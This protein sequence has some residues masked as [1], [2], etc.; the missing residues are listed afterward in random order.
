MMLRVSRVVAVLMGVVALQACATQEIEIREARV[1]LMEPYAPAAATLVGQVSLPT[2]VTAALTATVNWG[3]GSAE[4]DLTLDSSG[5]FNS[6]HSFANAGTYAVTVN[7]KAGLNAE[8][9]TTVTATVARPLANVSFECVTCDNSGACTVVADCTFD[10]PTVTF[11]ARSEGGINA[12]RYRW[13]F[14]DNS[15]PL[16][17]EVVSHDFANA[18]TYSVTVVA[19][20]SI[21]SLDSFSKNVVINSIPV[22]E[23]E[24]DQMLPLNNMQRRPAFQGNDSQAPATAILSIR[25]YGEPPITFIV[26]WGDMSNGVFPA[27][28]GDGTRFET[29]HVYQTA[30]TFTATVTGVDRLGQQGEVSFNYVVTP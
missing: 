12:I 27:Y 28:P 10:T 22:V 9:S 5:R 17:G 13:N 7:A 29:T 26:D 4:A 21:S 3:D 30:G 25:A 18:E 19:S 11:R 24:L 20:D 23:V 14:G 2:R 8:G 16:E 6:K 15:M 1:E